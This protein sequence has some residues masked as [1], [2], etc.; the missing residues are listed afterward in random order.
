MNLRPAGIPELHLSGLGLIKAEFHDA[1]RDH[2]SLEFQAVNTTRR[3]TMAK[4]QLSR[5]SGPMQL[6][7]ARQY[8]LAGKMALKPEQ[9]GTHVEQKSVT[10]FPAQPRNNSGKPFRRLENTRQPAVTPHR[11]QFTERRLGILWVSCIDRL[12]KFSEPMITKE[13]MA[14]RTQAKSHA[15]PAVVPGGFNY[16]ER[17][18]PGISTYPESQFILKH[19]LTPTR[20]PQDRYSSLPMFFLFL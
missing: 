14:F 6:H 2:D 5:T 15:S 1:R 18:N 17:G 13:I 20:S 19:P 9:P 4:Q 8:R 16:T 7:H 11:S 3:L 12:F 10:R